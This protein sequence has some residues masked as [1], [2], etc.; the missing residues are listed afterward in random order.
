MIQNFFHHT[1]VN[2]TFY[3]NRFAFC[4]TMLLANLAASKFSHVNYQH[5]LA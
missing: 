2:G 4:R 5:T 1:L 3:F